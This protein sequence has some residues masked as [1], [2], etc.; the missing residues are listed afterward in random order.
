MPHDRVDYSRDTEFQKLLRRQNDIDLAAAALEFARDFDPDVDFDA[1]RRWLGDRAREL[2]GPLALAKNSQMALE[3]LADCLCG[4]HGLT[5]QAHSY[6]DPEASFLHR[7]I[8]K[9]CG[10][11]ISLS[12]VYMAVA[13]RAGLPLR[14][15]CS[16]GYFITR[17]DGPEGPL[18][19][20]AYGSGRVLQLDECVRRIQQA[21]GL[22]EEL[23]LQALQP[24]RPRAILIR[25]LNNLKSLFSRTGK[26]SDALRVQHRLVAIQPASYAEKRDLGLILLKA[27]RPG[28][29]SDMLES[30]LK[31]CPP[32]ER[33]ILSEQLTDATQQIARWN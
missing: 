6:D 13:Q 10:L 19:L 11:P 14:G 20:D 18:F 4:T 26:W 2:A 5:G 23:T 32:D 12:V 27:G 15:V 9:K 25:M 1:V 3:E 24:A 33:T 29:A 22:E 21:T 17:Y 30:C 8:E 31:N 16:P 7:V 28:A